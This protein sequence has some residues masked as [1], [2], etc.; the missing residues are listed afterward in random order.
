MLFSPECSCQSLLCAEYAEELRAML[1]GGVKCE[2]ETLY[3]LGLGFVSVFLEKC[4]QERD[5][6]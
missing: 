2:L 3:A 5:Y 4:L 6:V 1:Q